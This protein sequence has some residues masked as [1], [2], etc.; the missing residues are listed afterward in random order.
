MSYKRAIE[1]YHTLISFIFIMLFFIIYLYIIS[2]SK[3][4][5]RERCLEEKKISFNGKIT[6]RDPNIIEGHI[7]LQVADVSYK[8]PHGP[9][10]LF[11]NAG[12]MSYIVK[13]KNINNYYHYL[14]ERR[15][16]KINADTNII[17]THKFDCSCYNKDSVEKYYR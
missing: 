3:K 15:E 2:P 14:L 12:G 5:L 6:L 13:Y 8:I 17:E 9:K 10:N 16:G 1:N 4:D 7:V 11:G